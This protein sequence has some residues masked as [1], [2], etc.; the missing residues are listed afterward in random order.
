MALTKEERE[1]INNTRDT[2]IELKAVLLGT[3]SDKG[4]VGTVTRIG[5]G[6]NRLTKAFWILVGILVGSGVLAVDKLGLLGG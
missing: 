3:D 6:H 1:I 2:V 5:N 4:L